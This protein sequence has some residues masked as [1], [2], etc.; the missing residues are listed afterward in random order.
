[1]KVLIFLVALVPLLRLIYLGF[2]NDLSANPIE[3][4]TRS[5]GTWALVLLCVTLAMTPLRMLT[6][7]SIWIR[8]RRMLGLFSFFYACIHFGIWIWLDLDFDLI[9]MWKDVVKRP[10]ITMGFLSFVFMI[11]LALT[12]N[13]WAQKKLGR[14]WSFLHRT[15]YVMAGT[16]ILHYWWHKV[17]KNDLQAV[18]IYAGT[19]IFL[20]TLR[21]PFIKQ[22]FLRK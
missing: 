20:L 15:I 2:T 7:S 21:L 13:H 18:S 5:T 17:G 22:R 6:G 14:R 12:S 10:F 9:E 1:M 19:I 16:V 3:F 8:Y 4:I 11:P